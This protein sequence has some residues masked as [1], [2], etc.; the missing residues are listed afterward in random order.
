MEGW[1]RQYEI[2]VKSGPSVI[3]HSDGKQGLAWAKRQSFY[4]NGLDA[5]RN[6]RDEEQRKDSSA[7]ITIRDAQTL[8]LCG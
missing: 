5:A 3:E 1:M 8:A 2:V 7:V 6:K 4:R